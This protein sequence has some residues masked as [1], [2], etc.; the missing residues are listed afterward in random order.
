MC[1]NYRERKERKQQIYFKIPCHPFTCTEWYCREYSEKNYN[2]LSV[3]I[4]TV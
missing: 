3:N 4:K 2:D 1:L